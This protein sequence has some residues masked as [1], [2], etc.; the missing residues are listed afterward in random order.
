MIFLNLAIC[1]DELASVYLLKQYIEDY[2][3]KNKLNIDIDI[4]TQADEFLESHTQYDIVCMDIYL[5]ENN[6]IDVIKRKDDDACVI[7]ITS[8]RDFAVEAFSLNAV[9]YLLKPINKE[10]LI[11][12]LERCKTKKPCEERIIEVKSPIGNV[13]IPLKKIS[14]IEVFNKTSVIHLKNTEIKTYTSLDALMQKLDADTFFRAQRSYVVNMH[15]I[16]S[17]YSDYIILKNKI[18]IQLSRKNKTTLK[19]QY[20]DFLFHLARGGSEGE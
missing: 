6:G 13:S 9:H 2:A 1:D 7:F 10:M 16:E 15:Y 20:Q 17:F 11:E 8:S 4:F 14:Y 12:A 3:N 18:R 5:N 19:K